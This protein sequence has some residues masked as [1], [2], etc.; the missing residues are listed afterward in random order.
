LN[1][2][3]VLLNK[4]VLEFIPQYGERLATEV[5]KSGQWIGSEAEKEL[6]EFYPKD[7]DGQ[8]P[9]A[10]IWAR[11]IQCEGPG[12][13]A[14]VPLITQPVLAERKSGKIVIRC[15]PTGNNG[16][17]TALL[18]DVKAGEEISGNVMRSSVTCPVCGYTTP[19]N[20][21]RK[22]FISRRGGAADA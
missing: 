3:P 1:P 7:P 16:I 19:A 21:V 22:Q 5:R 15:M 11:T 9:I 4:V 12:C 18:Y 14:I 13:G 17:R 20:S 10:F 8:M 6:G 2:V